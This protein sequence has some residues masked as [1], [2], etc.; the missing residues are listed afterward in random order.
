MEKPFPCCHINF[1][2][3]K[4][5][6]VQYAMYSHKCTYLVVIVVADA[7]AVVVV[8]FFAKQMNQRVSCCIRN[9][10]NCAHR[11][12]LTKCRCCC[13]Q[14]HTTMSFVFRFVRQQL[15]TSVLF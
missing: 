2:S 3:T 4:Y 6:T 5:S 8:V 11:I 7:E 13:R 10:C 9:D 14:A 15:Q 1:G 12:Y